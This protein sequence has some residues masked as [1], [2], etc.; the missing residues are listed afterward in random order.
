MMDRPTHVPRVMSRVHTFLHS[1]INPKAEI[2][3]SLQK[4]PIFVSNQAVVHQIFQ[5]EP[6]EYENI[7]ILA[8]ATFQKFQ[9]G[10]KILFTI[11]FQPVTLNKV[12]LVPKFLESHP[13]S[14]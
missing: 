4:A 8:L 9:I 5:T 10:P 6:L 3:A 11:S 13:L 7:S 14:L 2:P 1:K 12:I